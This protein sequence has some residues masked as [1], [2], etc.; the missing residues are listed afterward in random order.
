MHELPAGWRLVPLGNAGSW[1]SGGTPLTDNPRYWSGE[2]PWISAASLNE[3]H[4]KESYRRVTT[5]GARSG[6]QL[7]PA[8]TVVFVVRGMSLKKEFRVG[9]AQ[10]QI[11]F[12]QDCKAIIP[13]STIDGTFLALAM[14]ARTNE[15]LRMVDEAGHGTG[16]LPTDLISRLQI[17]IPRMEEQQRIVAILQALDQEIHN[18]QQIITKCSLTYTGLLADLLSRVSGDPRPLIDFLSEVPQNGFSPKEVHTWTGMQALGLGC[19]TSHGFEPSQL[20]NVPRHDIRNRAALLTDGDL[21]ISR[22]NTR[23][24]VGLVG[25]YRDIGAPCIYPDLMMRLKP[26]TNCRADFLE[27]VLRGPYIRRQIKVNAQGTSESMVKISGTSLAQL[28]VVIPSLPEQER[29]VRVLDRGKAQ[30]Q[31]YQKKRSKLSILKQG[32]MDDL[33]TGR[34]RAPVGDGHDLMCRER[35]T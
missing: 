22:A 26:K 12:G 29:V 27:A 15:I 20:K 4:I 7:V 31:A 16:R 25:R 19:L 1:L 9:V 3:F 18:T 2:T 30:I 23:D 8:G 32:L 10:R 6:T 14:K 11:A 33:L 21:L 17:P 13:F 24:Q 34:V 35:G 28:R 5:L